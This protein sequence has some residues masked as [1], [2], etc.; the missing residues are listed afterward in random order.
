MKRIDGHERYKEVLTS[1]AHFAFDE[2]FGININDIFIN[3]KK[4]VW[5]LTIFSMSKH[6]KRTFT[7]LC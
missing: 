3:Q 4:R 6:M 2:W 1:S 7:A 5:F